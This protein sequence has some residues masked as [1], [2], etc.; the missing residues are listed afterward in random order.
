MRPIRVFLLRSTGVFL[1][2][3]ALTCSWS[4]LA[5]ATY[6]QA[7]AF[8]ALLLPPVARLAV[9]FRDDRYGLE[10]TVSLGG[11]LLTLCVG[12]G[13]VLERTVP[14]LWIVT[15]SALLSGAGLLGVWLYGDREGWHNISK[16][17]GVIGIAVLAYLFTWSEMWRGIGWDHIRYEWRFRTWGI[18]LDAGIT[19]AFLAGW[20]VA[21]TRAFRKH[22]LETVALALFPVV[23]TAGFL[24]GSCGNN[25]SANAL[26]F[27]V[28][29]LALGVLYIVLGCRNVKL[30]QLNGGMALVSLLLI[31]RFF[32]SDFSYLVRG[33]VFMGLG[34]VFLTA[35]LVMARHKKTKELAI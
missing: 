34:A 10:T 23:A 15:Y 3:L 27:N 26:L 12:T 21:A 8:W 13:I 6:G 33:L 17:F 22:S 1:I 7:V 25:A 16:T 31:T 14:G 11:V 28:F 20:A 4:G 9:Q 18:W 24:I 5:Q 35:N 2:Y 29:T 32:D 19:L 30:R